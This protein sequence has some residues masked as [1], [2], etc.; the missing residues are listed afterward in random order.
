MRLSGANYT[1][2]D[3]RLKAARSIKP[4]NCSKCRL[5]C[6]TK[7]TSEQR[8]QLF[9]AFWS[10]ANYERQKDYVCARIEE[11]GT[12][13]YLDG[14]GRTKSKRKQ[15][16]RK[17]FLE[18]E[19]EKYSVCKKFFMNTLSIG[20]AYIDHAMKCKKDGHF[21]GNDLRG[22]HVPHNKLSKSRIDEVKKHIE[23][24]P[25]V[26][27]HY[28]RKETN[29]QFL[30]PELTLRKMYD[31][32][33]EECKSNDRDPVK[34]ETYRN[35]FN[36][37]YNLS[38]HVP[39]KD[40]C[41]TCN[42]YH[43]ALEEGTVTAEQKDD[44]EK[45]QQ[46]KKRAREEKE[47]DKIK[48][49]SQSNVH[50]AC[51]DLQSVLYTPCSLVSVMYYMRKLCCY[52]LTFYSLGDH[53][54]TCFVWSEVDAKRGASEV[55]TCLRLHLQSLPVNVDH[56]VLYS[57]ACGGQNRNKIIA[58]CLLHSVVTLPNI[59]V[60]DHKFLE[61]G[62]THMEVDSMHAAVEF[63][64]KKT[65]FFVPS[66]WDTVLQMARRRNPYTVVPLKHTD[67]IDF[68]QYQSINMKPQKKTESGAKVIWT[69]IKW[70]RYIK[71]EPEV[72]YFKNDIDG[73]F[74]KLKIVG[75]RRQPANFAES[76][77]MKYQS[78]LPISAEKKK[79]LIQ[80]CKNGVIPQEFHEYYK[81]LPSSNS[82]KDQLPEPDVIEESNSD[83]DFD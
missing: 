43:R 57:D 34:L 8:Q 73:E 58:S 49:Q 37:N 30:A 27:A 60:I 72:C 63:A 16:A 3:G 67:I 53:K 50:V 71:D 31:L 70:M 25:R 61:S 54:G 9:D 23:S 74:E 32:Y 36:K 20:R 55:A 19:S 81:S 33:V 22:K 68:K 40:Q 11:T 5:K 24:F 29:R 46:R 39:K 79:D 48:A 52:N 35:V 21:T 83:L 75:S 78:K 42:V 64:K 69:K 13:T 41:N 12:K 4:V 26:N 47:T 51:F 14:E 17:F 28:V 76:L 44:Y 82:K 38:F 2:A 62:H 10:L 66:Q 77:P 45:H 65:K 1:S 6:E 15:V 80:L 7:I 59:K 18:I 56:V